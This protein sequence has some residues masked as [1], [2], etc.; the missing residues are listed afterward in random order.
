MRSVGKTGRIPLVSLLRLENPSACSQ[1][2]DKHLDC[3]FS[4]VVRRR[5]FI[6]EPGSYPIPLE[7]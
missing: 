4:K 3:V 2:L 1:R 7:S 5:C 6:C